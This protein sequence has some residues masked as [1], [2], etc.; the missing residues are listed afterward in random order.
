MDYKGLFKRKKF[1]NLTRTRSILI[2]LK[3]LE[4]EVLHRRQQ[5]PK[6]GHNQTLDKYFE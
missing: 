4:L 1:K 2:I 6:T 5:P 3:G